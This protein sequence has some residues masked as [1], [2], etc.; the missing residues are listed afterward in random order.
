MS[1]EAGG[2]C[3]WLRPRWDPKQPY[4]L[5]RPHVIGQPSRPRWFTDPPGDDLAAH[6]H[7]WGVRGVR[8]RQRDEAGAPVQGRLPPADAVM[9]APWGVGGRRACGGPR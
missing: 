8:R 2:V 3:L 4:L 9:P 5:P 7:A 6:A 1:E